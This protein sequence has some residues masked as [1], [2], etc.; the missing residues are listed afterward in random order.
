MMFQTFTLLTAAVFLI[1]LASLVIFMCVQRG[2]AG[3]GSGSKS[4][5][6]PNAPAGKGE[7]DVLVWI[8]LVECTRAVA[9]VVC[10]VRLQ[11]SSC[12]GDRPQ[13]ACCWQRG[14]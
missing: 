10:A 9:G 13:H 2:G 6:N 3:G 1:L 11:V 12:V 14:V 5:Y 7:I 8:C 4:S